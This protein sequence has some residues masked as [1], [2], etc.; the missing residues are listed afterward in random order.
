MNRARVS[1]ATFLKMTIAL[2]RLKMA[3]VYPSCL[4]RLSCDGQ[5]RD[6]WSECIDILMDGAPVPSWSVMQSWMN[7]TLCDVKRDLAV[8]LRRDVSIAH[9]FISRGEE[10]TD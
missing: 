8:P 9:A 2:V 1:R 3:T 7:S 10:T 6:E 5:A 4:N